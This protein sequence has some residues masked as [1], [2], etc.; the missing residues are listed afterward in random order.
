MNEITHARFPRQP[1]Q[2]AEGLPRWR[3]TLAEFDKMIESGLLTED[4][5]VELI[6]G[7]LVP[8]AAKG[9]RHELVKT[10]LINWMFRRLGVN[11]MLTV[12]L[13]WRPGGDLYVEPDV[14]IYGRGPM[15]SQ[16]PAP[17][18]LL[19]IE[20]SDSSLRYDLDRKAMIYASLGVREYWVIDANTLETMVHLDP[21]PD[22][23][24]DIANVPSHGTVT[25]HLL[26]ALALSLGG[27]AI[28]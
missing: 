23:Y 17:D 11:E 4:D 15:P 26:P 13:G 19:V 27:L 21:A 8:M 5:R 24:R 9:N 3:W 2:G 20:I 14:V 16:V 12:E 7:E 10:E 1:T 6:D 18:T 22:G 25:P 28:G